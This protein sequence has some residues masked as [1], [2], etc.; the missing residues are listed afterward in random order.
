MEFNNPPAMPLRQSTR[1][2]FGT[3]LMPVPKNLIEL[4]GETKNSEVTSD[5][6]CLQL[7]S[8]AVAANGGLGVGQ[9]R[10]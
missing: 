1:F 3:W 6:D 8:F 7:L 10:S 9:P 5:A 2:W 4:P